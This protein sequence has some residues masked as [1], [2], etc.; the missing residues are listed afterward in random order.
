MWSPG[1]DLAL[2]AAERNLLHHSISTTRHG[3][4]VTDHTDVIPALG[5]DGG[6][7]NV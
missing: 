2:Q 6:I 5:A 4:V 3:I 7:G 1:P